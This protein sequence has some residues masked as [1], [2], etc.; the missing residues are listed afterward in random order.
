MNFTRTEWREYLTRQTKPPFGAGAFITINILL[1]GEQAAKPDRGRDQMPF[2]SEQGCSGWINHELDKAGIPEEFC[3][4][5]NALNNDGSV[6]DFK[7]I[8]DKLHPIAVFV[9]GNIA[10]REFSK[11]LPNH[12]YV[13]VPHPQYWKRFQSGKPYPL[14]GPLLEMTKNI[15]P[16]ARSILS[17]K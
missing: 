5:L 4:W 3:F 6:V 11:A 15:H 8:V 16:T 14:I 12:Q 13:H 2:C 10:K 17:Y 1:I 9:L 7:Q